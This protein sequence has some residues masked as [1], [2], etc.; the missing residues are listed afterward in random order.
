MSQIPVRS[1]SYLE[2]DIKRGGH[3]YGAMELDVLGLCTSI[4]RL[5]MTGDRYLARSREMCS[6]SC[7]CDQPN[8][9]RGR[10]IRL[11][12]LK[13]LE[14]ERFGG[15]NHE[16]DLLKVIFRSATM[17]QRVNLYF[18]SDVSPESCS[19]YKELPSILNAYPL[20]KFHIYRGY[21]DPILFQ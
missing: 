3:V 13:E 7:L 15:E 20:V 14:V 2:L 6:A 17:L 12:N 5:K 18:S 9:W 1:F 21:R 11:P 19:V 4:Q 8:N 16:A 10:S